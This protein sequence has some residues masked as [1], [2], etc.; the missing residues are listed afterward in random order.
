MIKGKPDPITA[1][2]A[3]DVG[4]SAGQ[5]RGVQASTVIGRER[6]LSVLSDGL[7]KARAGNWQLWS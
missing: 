1:F 4:G 5:T 7:A 6:E 2:A 3:Y